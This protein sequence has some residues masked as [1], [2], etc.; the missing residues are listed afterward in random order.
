MRSDRCVCVRRT[1]RTD[2]A[3]R[4]WAPCCGIVVYRV[5]MI[6]F[7]FKQSHSLVYNSR[8]SRHD[9]DFSTGYKP[10]IAHCST[11][12]VLLGKS[13]DMWVVGEAPGV[14]PREQCRGM[15]PARTR[16]SKALGIAAGT[17]KIWAGCVLC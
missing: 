12:L 15:E 5:R 14:A 7:V 2:R 8:F 16:K 13:G 9:R 17:L 10:G 3:W 11:S 1:V 4:I 6:G